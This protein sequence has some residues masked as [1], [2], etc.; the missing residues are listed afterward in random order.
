MDHSVWGLEEVGAVRGAP[1]WLGVSSFMPQKAHTPG[2]F[3]NTRIACNEVLGDMMKIVTTFKG[4]SIQDVLPVYKSPFIIFNATA[5]LRQALGYFRC[6]VA[7]LEVNRERM[8]EIVRDGYSGAPDL[9]ITLIRAKGF[10]G[11]RAHR[12]CCNFVRLAR[13][14][15]IKP[16]ETTG[17]LL[18]EAARVTDEP[19]PGLTDEEVQASMGLEHFFE[20]HREPGGPHPDETRR[21]AAKRREALGALRTEQSERRR[22]LAEA[23]ER[24]QAEMNAI[25]GDS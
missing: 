20:K 18:D 8:R 15:D 10:G 24:L 1:E 23:D 3:E 6:L 12:I 9:A 14:R 2:M 13:E 11:R 4:E 5:H 21:L 19:E 17:A 25:V 16:C 22:R 7:T